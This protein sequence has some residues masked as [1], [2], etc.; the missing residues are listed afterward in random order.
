MWLKDLVSAVK[1]YQSGYAFL[2]SQ[3]GVFV[4]HPETRWIMRE[5]IFSIAE[6]R[7]DP[8][9]RRLGRDMIG[10]ERLRIADRFFTGQKSWLYYAPLPSTGWSLGVM[11][12]ESQLFAEVSRLSR[13]TSGSS[14]WAC[15]SW[16]W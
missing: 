8:A 13:K 14:W 11:F 9:L 16:P 15:S 3:N 5:S 4:T 1:I 2:I 7:G 12:P 6:A 10:G